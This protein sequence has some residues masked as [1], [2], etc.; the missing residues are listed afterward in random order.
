MPFNTAG[1]NTYLN[2]NSRI[3]DRLV[4]VGNM[5]GRRQIQ[6]DQ[7]ATLYEL[8]DGDYS[9]YPGLAQSWEVAD[10]GTTIIFNLVDQHVHYHNGDEMTS[11]DIKWSIDTMKDNEYEGVV[12]SP[13]AGDLLSKNI[14]AV[15]TPDEKTV[16][17]RLSK[18]TG[19]IFDYFRG[20]NIG[21]RPSIED[22]S[23]LNGNLIGTGPFIFGNYDPNVGYEL[24]RNADYWNNAN[25]APYLD[26]VE[27]TIFADSGAQGLAFEAGDI[28][29]FTGG[30]LLPEHAEAIKGN[31]KWTHETYM[32]QGGRVFRLRAD[33]LDKRVRQGLM[34]LVDSERISAEYFGEFDSHGY[35]QWQ[36]NSLAYDAAMDA[37]LFDPAEAAKL[38]SA[39]GMGDGDELNAEV[40]PE[41]LDA[42]ATA[43]IIQQELGQMGINLNIRNR[44]YSEMISLQT[45]G[46]FEHMLIGFGNWIKQG[47]PALTCLFADSYDGRMNAPVESAENLRDRPGVKDELEWL[48]MIE[49]VIDGTFD[50]YKA[51]NE[52][53]HDVAWSRL[54]CRTNGN[55][56]RSPNVQWTGGHENLGTDAEGW[57]YLKWAQRAEG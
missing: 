24:T 28:D 23:V 22:G 41:R 25:D 2:Q 4:E 15:E 5:K 48:D 20:A 30:T 52:K 26:K 1:N 19:Y 37:P 21:H 45:T 38:I 17:V 11:E 16:V 13:Y 8:Y 36:P 46:T 7:E 12:G 47:S 32:G 18:P 33:L 9:V 40:L 51:W 56:F 54:V 6:A 14:T 50:D 43:Q 29:L 27:S 44:E 57:G 42:P 10:G 3:F 34:R 49:G 39:A 35:L 31:S 55:R 53:F